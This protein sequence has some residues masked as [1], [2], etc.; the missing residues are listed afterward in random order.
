AYESGIYAGAYRLLDATNM[1]GY[2]VASFMLPYI[3]RRWSTK[4][5][6]D[7]V[8]LQ[9]R[10]FLLMLSA[11][12]VTTSFFLGPWIQRV[13]Y[14]HYDDYAVSVLQW[15]LPAIA[16]YSLL[17]IYGTALTATGRVIDLCY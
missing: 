8:V 16:G 10:H 7:S 14:H 3:A 1:S 9:C 17:H 2:L 4:Q 11:G 12:I 5:E 13:L 6:I 15:C